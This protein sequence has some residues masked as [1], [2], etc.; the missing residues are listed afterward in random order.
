MHIGSLVLA[1]LLTV[2]ADPNSAA[3]TPY[4]VWA[5][6]TPLLSPGG[7]PFA[8][9]PKL[10]LGEKVLVSSCAN[11]FCAVTAPA[12]QRQGW[13]P[14]GHLGPTPPTK[15]QL[16]ARAVSDLERACALSPTH[17][18][19]R[20]LEA[21]YLAVGQRKRAAVVDTQ[22]KE[23]SLKEAA[24]TP[25]R[26]AAVG[27]VQSRPSLRDGEQVLALCPE[28]PR[29]LPVHVKDYGVI[30]GYGVSVGCKASRGK[31]PPLPVYAIAGLPRSKVRVGTLEAT[32]ARLGDQEL[33]T[34]E[35][36]SLART[37]WL[38]E[39]T[40]GRH[41]NLDFAEASEFSFAGDLD[42]DGRLDVIVATVDLDLCRR[43][44]LLLLSSKS[45][46]TQL[47]MIAARAEEPVEC[48]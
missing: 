20:A 44:G 6:E 19:L 13:L 11:G 22:A 34:G 41:M 23:L 46:V 31:A 39:P 42:G 32:V 7:V 16:A 9:G 26:F 4:Y 27:G 28:G 1:V 43:V 30:A 37:V 33:R 5:H 45:N 25:V 10:P 48:E 36:T 38:W 29:W 3:G 24:R 2:D 47:P 35:R 21:A 8:Q 17:T 15:Q 12:Y 14:E 40:S 18:C